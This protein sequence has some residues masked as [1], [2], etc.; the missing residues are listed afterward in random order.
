V[1]LTAEAAAE[2]YER[3]C[4]GN[5]RCWIMGGWGVDAL[6]GSHTREHHDLDV[7]VLADDVRDLRRLFNDGGFVIMHVWV[8]ENRWLDVDGETWPTAF[9][10]ADETGIELDV[11]VVDMREGVVVPLCNVPWRFDTES[12]DGRGLISGRPIA[13]V[14]ARTQVAM[15]DGYDLPE[16]H[17][18]DLELL[19][20]LM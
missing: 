5:I 9:V 14:S 6:V 8:V 3:L 1:N 4:R 10:A 19:R 12:L 18:R 7:L 11:H 17:R 20:Q 16:P 13:C 15:H 2:L